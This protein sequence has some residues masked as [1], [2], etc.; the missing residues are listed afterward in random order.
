VNEETINNEERQTTWKHPRTGEERKE[1]K[2]GGREGR[3]PEN[4]DNINNI[5]QRRNPENFLLLY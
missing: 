2:E 3:T 4:G 5:K 1:G